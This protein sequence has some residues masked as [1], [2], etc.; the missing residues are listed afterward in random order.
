MASQMVDAL[1]DIAGQGGG[2]ML[3]TDDMV[4]TAFDWMVHYAKPAAAAAAEKT[5][6]EANVKA[7]RGR[8]FLGY[9][10]TVAERNAKAECHPD[11]L[12]ATEREAVA[13][14]QVI[15]HVKKEKHAIAVIDAWRTESA[16]YRGRERIG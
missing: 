4:Q 10:G 12:A 15:W 9:V 14:E 13:G 3:I 6:A 11:L 5:R 2:L 16:N 1:A 8:L 7:T